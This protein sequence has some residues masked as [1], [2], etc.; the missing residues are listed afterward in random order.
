MNTEN[1]QNIDLVV[2]NLTAIHPLLG[3]S[4]T[5]AIRSKTTLTP[6][7]LFVMGVL[8][9][10]EKLTMSEIACRLSVPKPHV[11]VMIDKLI[12]EDLVE[13]L[14]DPDDRRV[15]Y[16]RLNDKG[17][18]T[19]A[20]VRALISME[21]YQKLQSLSDEQMSVL[22]IASQQVKDI[23]MSVLL[24]NPSNPELRCK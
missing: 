17:I 6:G 19:Y 16:I 10:H 13:R 20:S 11:T 4:F 22:S 3:K 14:S 2:E 8:V 15:V 23:L 1:K 21:L 18:E 24:E 7:I 5:K 9:K 12:S